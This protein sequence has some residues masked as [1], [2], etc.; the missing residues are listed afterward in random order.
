M[1]S[2]HAEK[3]SPE[4]MRGHFFHFLFVQL[5]IICIFAALKL[6]QNGKLF[7]KQNKKCFPKK[8]TL[9]IHRGK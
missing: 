5:E 2:H 9:M 7:K 4:M 8:R 3:K 1:F 6:F